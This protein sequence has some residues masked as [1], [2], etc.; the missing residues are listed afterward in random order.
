MASMKMVLFVC[1]AALLLAILP[2]TSAALTYGTIVD[3]PVASPNYRN[4]YKC[5]TNK[6]LF[7]VRPLPFL[8]LTLQ[9]K[10][11]TNK[12]YATPFLSKLSMALL[13]SGFIPSSLVYL[14]LLD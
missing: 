9:K 11:K 14:L 1:L 6:Y 3:T 2:F 5:G 13:S 4:F 8:L 7:Q 12:A 10:K